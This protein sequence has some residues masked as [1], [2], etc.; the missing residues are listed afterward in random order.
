M[1]KETEN[2]FIMLLMVLEI[3][4]FS[5]FSSS[6]VCVRVL[7]CCLEMFTHR[8]LFTLWLLLHFHGAESVVKF[9]FVS[10]SSNAYVIY[11]K[12]A[13]IHYRGLR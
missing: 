7:H 11:V 8:N 10:K 5:F 13:E 3:S 9:T 1:C 6:F 2:K 4:Y 12:T